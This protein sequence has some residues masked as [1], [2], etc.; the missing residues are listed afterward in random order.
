[1]RLPSSARSRNDSA[2]QRLDLLLEPRGTT[3]RLGGLHALHDRGGKP[4]HEDRPN[5]LQRGRVARLVR[6]DLDRHAQGR[7][8]ARECLCGGSGDEHRSEEPSR[9][10]RAQQRDVGEP[11]AGLGRERGELALQVR[12]GRVRVCVDA[13]RPQPGQSSFRSVERR[14]GAVDAEHDVATD[15]SRS[16]VGR[17]G[18]RPN[19]AGRIGIEA[20]NLHPRSRQVRRQPPAGLTEPED[21]SPSE[22]RGLSRC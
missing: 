2:D 15:G 1:M 10:D 17:P 6:N 18:D 4:L 5:E 7:E 19:V 21:G 20:A 9:R 22:A 14:L 16:C 12:G 11:D 8:E 13:T 3:H